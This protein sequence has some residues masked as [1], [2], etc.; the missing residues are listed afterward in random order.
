MRRVTS[1]AVA[2]SPSPSR[3]TPFDNTW[4]AQPSYWKAQV[5]L[6]QARRPLLLQL[7][8]AP[9]FFLTAMIAPQ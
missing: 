1:R 2:P 4:T 3:S 7:P 9:R 8:V 5:T 6:V